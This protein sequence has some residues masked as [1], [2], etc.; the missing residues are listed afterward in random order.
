[1]ERGRIATSRPADGRRSASDEELSLTSEIFQMLAN[2]T[3]LRIVESL[4]RAELRVTE[5]AELVGSTESAVSHHL[6][7]L[8]LL[9]IVRGRR[10]GRSIYYRLDDEHVATLLDMGLEHV[11]EI[12]A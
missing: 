10:D 5:L 1:M 8:R 9:R 3:R 7:Q 11:R 4:S 12:L 2:P 6:R